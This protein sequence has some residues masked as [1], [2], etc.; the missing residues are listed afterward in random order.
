MKKRVAIISLLTTCVL[1]ASLHIEWVEYDNGHLLVIDGTHMDLR[2]ELSEQWNKVSRQC[3]RI[4]L[5]S[6]DESIHA[7]VQSAIMDYSPPQSSSA[8]V[9]S[10][11]SA[12]DW[13]LAEVEF[14][15]L[16]PAVVLINKSTTDL[17]IVSDAVWSGST[18]PW[19]AAPHIRNYLSN[20]VTGVSVDL[21][22]CFEPRSNAF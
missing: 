19:K 9:V 11:W 20:K 3:H 4:R 2:G 5:V 1:V 15:E 6:P 18:K 21:F 16:L 22:R 7:Q 17:T 12:D 14:K 10:L 8:N 13:L